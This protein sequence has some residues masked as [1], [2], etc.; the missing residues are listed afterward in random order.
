MDRDSWENAYQ[1]LREAENSIR[2]M[3]KKDENFWN[4][5]AEDMCIPLSVMNWI[6]EDETRL[7]DF[8][9]YFQ[10]DIETT[11]DSLCDYYMNEL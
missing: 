4:C 2:E 3:C 11:L 1:N 5:V 9:H 8:Q 6:C 7:K 10:Y